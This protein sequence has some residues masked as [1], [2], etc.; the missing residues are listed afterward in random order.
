MNPFFL[1]SKET[2]PFL[3]LHITIPEQEAFNLLARTLY[4][5]QSRAPH[6]IPL[7][8]WL[9]LNVRMYSFSHDWSQARAAQFLQMVR[10]IRDLVKRPMAHAPLLAKY[11]I[12]SPMKGATP[13]AIIAVKQRL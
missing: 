11:D 4:T 13:F 10:H 2:P 5:V 9:D 8:W 3:E 6:S 1:L 7:L 12:G